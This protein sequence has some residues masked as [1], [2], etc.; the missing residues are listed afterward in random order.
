MNNKRKNLKTK[1][2]KNTQKHKQNRN[3][4][5]KL[6]IEQ[7]LKRKIRKKNNPTKNKKN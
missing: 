4:T 7:Q 2:I 5:K 3:T 6:N 1:N